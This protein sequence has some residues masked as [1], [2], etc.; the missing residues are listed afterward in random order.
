M[1]ENSDEDMKEID[2]DHMI[3]EEDIVV[4]KGHSFDVFT[5]EWNP[6]KSIIAS[7][8][9]DGTARLW[10][11]LKDGSPSVPKILEHSTGED[12]QDNP[13]ITTLDWNPS[14][15]LLATGSYDGSARIWCYDGTLKHTLENHEGPIFS[16]RW[17]PQG[18]YLLSG[19]S[20]KT[21]IVWEAE[22]GKVKQQF[23]FH[24][25]Q[26]LDVDWRDDN[27]FATCSSEIFIGEVGNSKYLKCFKGHSRE[28]NAISWCP[29][30]KLLASCSDDCTAK[31]WSLDSA[32]SLQDF[33]EHKKELYTIKWSPTGPGT[34][35]PNRDLILASASF[36]A[37][38]KLWNVETGTCLRTLNRHTES[39]YSVE[40]SPDG[41][42]I[43]S[44]SFDHFLHIWSTATGEL[45][46]SY[47]S[48]G[49]IFEVSW[50]SRG[51]K[52]AASLDNNTVFVADLRL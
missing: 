30:G 43:A 19:S 11:I 2:E 15:T 37:T 47:E 33:R 12:N 24:S 36:D 48:S 29:A 3:P 41:Q 49:G 32:D 1:G 46:K 38:V 42:Y 45:V 23:S 22:S 50:N 7:G 20:D 39:V 13:D 9:G 28:V 16:V 26:I 6:R 44:G 31:I 51:N 25:A 18:N 4:L 5:C 10:K 17:N 14:G 27:T 52:L 35:N 21:A 34:S 8:S 40:F